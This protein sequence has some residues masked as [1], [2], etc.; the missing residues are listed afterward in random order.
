MEQQ[1]QDELYMK[2]CLQLARKAQGN[3]YPNPMVGAVIVHNGVIIGEGYHLKAGAPHAEVNAIN[4]VKN[5]ALLEKSTLYVNLEPCAHYGKTPPCSLLICQKKIP[6]VVIGC[7]DTFSKVAGKGIEILRAAGAEVIVGVLEK[8]SRE[9][10]RR[11]FTF[12]EKKRPFI[13][14]KWA[15][16]RDGFLD[17][18]RSTEAEPRPTWITDEWARRIVHQW[19]SMEQSILVG[20]MTALRDNPSLTVRDWS[21]PD[22]LRLVV[23]RHGKLPH[24][25]SLFKGETPTLVFTEKKDMT[26]EGVET[27]LLSPGSNT[28]SCILEELYRRDIQSVMV[29]GGSILLKAFLDAGLWDEA[30]VFVGEKWFVAGVKAPLIPQQPVSEEKFGNS[31]LFVFQNK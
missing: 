21:G 9:L 1:H 14:L 29:E 10:N 28:L 25:L 15:Q 7:K 12:H 27:V 24:T 16:T 22:P 20:T 26:L 5:P 18:D 3:T 31:R 8:E 2:R 4:A 17:I 6:R 23:D 13:L 19:R 11:F 30:R